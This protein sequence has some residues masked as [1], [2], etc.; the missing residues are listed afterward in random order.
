MP[1]LDKENRPYL[2][3]S[4][5]LSC[6]YMHAAFPSFKLPI[7][8]FL[9]NYNQISQYNKQTKWDLPLKSRNERSSRIIGKFLKTFDIKAAPIWDLLNLEHWWTAN[10]ARILPS[11]NDLSTG[12]KTLQD[13]AVTFSVFWEDGYVNRLEYFGAIG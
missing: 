3:K 8:Y 4:H 2:T 6:M 9:L 12:W 10:Q 11:K 13:K 5:Y 1:E 7:N